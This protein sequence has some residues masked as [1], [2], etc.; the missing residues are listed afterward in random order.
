MRTRPLSKLIRFEM[1]SRCKAGT[2]QS[3]AWTRFRHENKAIANNELRKKSAQI[4]SV[5]ALIT[6]LMNVDYFQYKRAVMS[7]KS[8]SQYLKAFLLIGLGDTILCRSTPIEAKVERVR[9]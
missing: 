7:N 5:L 8:W 1:F 4:K 6:V 9:H 2:C 3:T